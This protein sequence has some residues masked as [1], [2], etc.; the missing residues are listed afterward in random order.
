MIF[1]SSM[2]S[3]L[4]VGAG[5]ATVVCRSNRVRTAGPSISTQGHGRDQLAHADR[6]RLHGQHLRRHVNP[7]VTLGLGAQAAFPGRYVPAY[8]AASSA[9]LIAQQRAFA[10][11]MLR[12]TNA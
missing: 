11:Q 10:T 3:Q 6:G 1:P 12:T 9:G 2:G 7:A 8:L 4:A 5:G